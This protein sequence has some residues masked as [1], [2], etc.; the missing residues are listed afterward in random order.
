MRQ[1]V[2]LERPNGKGGYA[3]ANAI[4]ADFEPIAKNELPPRG[5][6]TFQAPDALGIC[7]GWRIKLK[8]GGHWFVRTVEYL[9]DDPETVLVTLAGTM[10]P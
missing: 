2:S 10:T 9:E 3:H 7:P 6:W 8:A 1:N 4:T 5:G